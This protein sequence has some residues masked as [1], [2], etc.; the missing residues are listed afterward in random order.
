MPPIRASSR[1]AEP[2]AGLS[3]ALGK[4]QRPVPAANSKRAHRLTSL[5]GISGSLAATEFICK[6]FRRAD[7][8][9]RINSEGIFSRQLKD[10]RIGRALNQTERRR[11]KT[12]YRVVEVHVIQHIEE[13]KTQF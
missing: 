4:D 3:G 12:A 2:R 7:Y 11:L 8:R 13:L 1:A 5:P 6:R 9:F 10:A